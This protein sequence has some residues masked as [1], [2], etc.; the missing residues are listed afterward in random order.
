MKTTKITIKN[1]FWASR[2]TTLDGKSDEISRP[3]GSGKT[4]V[5][6]A[7]RYALTN[8]SDRDYIVHQGADDGE[9]IIETNTGLSLTGR[10]CPPN[11]PAR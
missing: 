3:Q 2:E 4:S 7:I 1:L 5:L 9:V 8:R 6:D 10:P 11:P